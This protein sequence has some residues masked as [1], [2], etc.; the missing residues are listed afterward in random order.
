MAAFLQENSRG[1]E[2]TRWVKPRNPIPK[3]R[4]SGFAELR[5]YV[6]NLKDIRDLSELISQIE[7]DRKGVPVL[8]RQYLRLGGEVLGFN[9]DPRFMDALDALVLVDLTKTPPRTL[10]RYM[11]RAEAETFL[12]YHTR[13]DAARC[14]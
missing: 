7:H 8:I 2:P 10:S 1:A 14:A 5:G 4:L 6:K 11:G 3:G 12:S 13:P 9:V